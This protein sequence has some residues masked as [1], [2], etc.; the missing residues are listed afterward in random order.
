MRAIYLILCVLAFN[1]QAKPNCEDYS[2]FNFYP[3]TAKFTMGF[4]LK[5][6][7]IIK[8]GKWDGESEPKM[9]I[10]TAVALSNKAIESAKLA[11]KTELGAVS[12]RQFGC[13][14]PE[15]FY[16]DV[17]YHTYDNKNR[18]S[19]EYHVIIYQDGKVNMPIQVPLPEP[20]WKGITSGS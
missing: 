17:V 1:V 18:M 7:E 2:P 4:S 11:Y 3:A 14:A 20:P 10:S 6:S 8:A 15:Y 16:Y 5:K 12:L 13:S 19:G 9:K